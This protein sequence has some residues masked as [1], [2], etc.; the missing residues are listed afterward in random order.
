MPLGYVVSSYCCN[1]DIEF[2]NL[3][4]KKTKEYDSLQKVSSDGRR[5]PAES[6]ASAAD[7]TLADNVKGLKL[8]ARATGELSN[9]QINLEGQLKEAYKYN[10]DGSE[11]GSEN[12]PGGDGGEEENPLG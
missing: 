4:T 6:A 8:R 10:V 9:A 11:P 7:F 1:K 3:K 12:K 5:Q 2:F